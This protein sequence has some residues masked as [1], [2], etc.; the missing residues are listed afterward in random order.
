MRSKARF[1]EQLEYPE[2]DEAEHCNTCQFHHGSPRCAGLARGQEWTG[3]VAAALRF[4][5]AA[6][7]CDEVCRLIDECNGASL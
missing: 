6:A 5:D 2:Y 1:V 4:S 7:N 3:N